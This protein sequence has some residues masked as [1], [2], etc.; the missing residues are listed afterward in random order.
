MPDIKITISGQDTG[1]GAALDDLVNG[2]QKADNALD[3]LGGRGSGLDA[4]MGRLRAARGEM[5]SLRE[6]ADMASGAGQKSM[7]MGGA[8]LGALG[9]GVKA[10]LDAF[11]ELQSVEMG[12]ESMLGSPE[13][14][15]AKLAEL[16]EFA[17]KSPF[18]FSQTAKSAQQLLAMGTAA[19]DLIPTM[20]GVGNAVSAAGGNTETFQGVLTAL[21]QIRTKGKVSAEE[22]QQ[23]AERSI[24]A[25]KILQQELGL[26][27]EQVA[28]IG[29]E[30]IDAEVAIAALVR[31]MGKLGG[32]TA[33]EKQMETLPGKISAL[34]DEMKGLLGT[35]GEVFGAD[36]SNLV[37]SMTELVEKTSEFVK[38]NP[39]LVK[40]LALLT[41]GVGGSMVVGGGALM[42]GGSMA[43]GASEILSLTRALKGGRKA[44]DEAAK[45]KDNLVTSTV[46]DVAAEKLKTGVAGKEAG[47]LADVAD[48]ALDAAAAKDALGNSTTKAAGKMGILAKAKNLLGKNLIPDEALFKM[49][50]KGG[51]AGKAGMAL[52]GLTIGGTA[53]AAGGGLVAGIGASNNMQA[54]GYSEG[55]SYMYGAATGIGAAAASLFVPGGPVA[56]A[57]GEAL[58][59]GVNELYNKPME[60]QAENN[61]GSQLAAERQTKGPM[62]HQEK[63]AMYLEDARKMQ[64]QA[65]AETSGMWWG[66]SD[67]NAEAESLRRLAQNEMAF[68]RKE[69][70]QNATKMSRGNNDAVLQQ[71]MESRGMEYIPAGGSSPG[72]AAP[73]TRASVRDETGGEFDV[74]VVV[75]KVD[76]GRGKQA[77]AEQEYRNQRNR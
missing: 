73:R 27:Q 46:A 59:F 64:E 1:A 57:I 47:A 52:N 13:A 55:Q 37:G 35:I 63:A 18:D 36:A 61:Q 62:S 20:E 26:T 76:T 12:L 22:L 66:E 48:T 21:G 16:Q 72:S 38:Q 29:N 42:V 34:Q 44:A 30:G 50:G 6:A 51:M 19:D 28:N 68:A 58:A 53:L 54:A 77:P 2:A 71:W 10:S 23:M 67:K 60:D 56:V 8:A 11:G 24:P 45:A 40:T 5:D 15:K 65:D 74:Q 7:L 17:K 69:N 39:E 75:K 4:Y 9:A 41:A 25:T 3:R 70:E 32:G 43:R 49:L 14:A 31:G 33:M